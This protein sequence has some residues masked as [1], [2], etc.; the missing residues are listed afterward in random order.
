MVEYKT[1]C[2][3]ARNFH[4]ETKSSFNIFYF[5]NTVTKDRQEYSYSVIYFVIFY[6]YFT[7]QE[8]KCSVKF[9]EEITQISHLVGQWMKP[10]ALIQ[11][12]KALK[13]GLKK[14]SSRN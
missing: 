11:V 6:L 4:A 12:K 3:Y 13:A 14:S 9:P 10:Q 7:V 8:N 2:I 1:D 5:I